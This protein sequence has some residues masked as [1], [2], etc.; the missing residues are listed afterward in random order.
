MRRRIRFLLNGSEVEVE[1]RS[2]RVVLDWLRRDRALVGTKEGCREG[3]CGACLALF[4]PARPPRGRAPA[5]WA[6]VPTCLLALGELDG[7]SLATIEGL[8][9]AGPT[10]VMLALHAQGASQCGFCSPGVVVALTAFL[11][12]S[13]RVDAASALAAVDGNL[14][15]CTGY[16]SIR[17]AA[18]ALVADFDGLPAPGP[19][20][21]AALAARGVLPPALA[22][23]MSGPPPEGAARARRPAADGA[24]LVLGGGTDWFVR[25]PDPEGAADGPD[26][27]FTDRDASLT[28]IVRKDGLVE[29]GGG[30]SVRDFFASPLVLALAPA[31][32]DYERAFASGPVR[33]RATVAGNVANASPAGD[34]SAMLLAL[35]A[36][37][38][39]RP[40]GGDG[41]RRVIPLEAFFRGYKETAL[42]D[43]ERI[44]AVLLSD[45]PP[46]EFSFLKASRRADLDIAAVDSA[47]SFRRNGPAGSGA[48][49]DLRVSAGGVAPVPLLLADAAAVLE[50][51]PVDAGLVARAAS[52][53]AAACSPISDVRGSA[54]YRRALVDRFVRAH[55]LRL[56]PGALDP[57]ELFP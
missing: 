10:P 22:A 29:V 20:R 11:L 36:R 55:C 7:R 45:G 28:A 46:R 42:R 16:A 24:G 15:R 35:G 51:R 31:L 33:A 53:A 12:E 50:G 1:E 30:V 54:A 37:L 2:D 18:A 25:H 44:E 40:A 34:L 39:L 14:C 3:D 21:L 32:A 4:G 47:L 48:P 23:S 49:E 57:E 6:A 9:A 43:G 5:P 52:A 8:A 38:A 27:A 26:A 41:P 56:F 13:P 17:R 19:A